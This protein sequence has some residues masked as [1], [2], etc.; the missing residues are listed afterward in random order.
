MLSICYVAPGQFLLAS[1]GPTRNVLNLATALSEYADVTVAFRRELDQSRQH[2][3]NVLEI[4]PPKT[5]QVKTVLDDAAVRG[6]S[7]SEF[8]RYAMLLR[9]FARRELKR[10]DLVFEKSWTLSGLVSAECRK[11]GVPAIT[12]ENLVPVV[13]DNSGAGFAKR[14]KIWAGRAVAGRYLRKANRIIAE[15]QIL[16]SAMEAHWRIA[17]QRISVVALGVDRTLFAPI[18]QAT[19]RSQVGMSPNATVLLYSGVLDQTHDLRPAIAAMSRTKLRDVELHIIGDGTLRGELERLATDSGGAVQFHGRVPYEMVPLY[20]G[21]ADLC[22]APYEPGA[23]PGGQIAYSSLKIPEYMSVGRPVA[24]VP[25]GRILELINDGVTGFL[26][27]NEEDEWTR[28]LDELPNRDRLA[29]MG[30][31][32]M[33]SGL[34]SW[35]DVARAYLEIGKTEIENAN[36]RHAN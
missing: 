20:I 28:F 5:G 8:A 6:V 14:T 35:D 34:D 30:A 12:V 1:A 25:S 26:F 15:T 10:F 3:L 31:S 23:F 2:G 33:E 27:P 16:K 7:V 4:D 21:A 36:Q 24:S 9:R 22:L 17:E 11:I 29:S 19:A 13:G 32:A 18:D